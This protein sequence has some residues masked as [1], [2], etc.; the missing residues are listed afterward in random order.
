[1]T[2]EADTHKLGDSPRYCRNGC[3]LCGLVDCDVEVQGWAQTDFGKSPCLWSRLVGSHPTVVKG[4]YCDFPRIAP[5]LTTRDSLAHQVGHEVHADKMCA[6]P[7]AP[8]RLAM[9]RSSSGVSESCI[10]LAAS[11]K[12]YEAFQHSPNRFSGVRGRMGARVKGGEDHT[13]WRTRCWLQP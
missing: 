2:Y 5:A 7:S 4:Y 3:V 8:C 6:H 12:Q 9:H 13:A 11:M 10:A 1:M